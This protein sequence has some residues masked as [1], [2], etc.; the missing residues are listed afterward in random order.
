[1]VVLSDGAADGINTAGAGAAAAVDGVPVDGIGLG[2]RGE[3][4]IEG[5]EQQYECGSFDENAR[6]IHWVRSGFFA[7]PVLY[8]WLG[9]E[10]VATF[11]HAAVFALQRYNRKSP[12]VSITALISPAWRNCACSTCCSSG[13]R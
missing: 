13:G 9:M 5:Q 11:K 3:S 6:G 8:V 7:S 10:K 4:K 2:L 12:G 1:G